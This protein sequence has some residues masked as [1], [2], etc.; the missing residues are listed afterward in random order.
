MSYLILLLCQC[1]DQLQTLGNCWADEFSRVATLLTATSSI[2]Y[3]A[4]LG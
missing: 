1:Y 3:A 2:E 4:Y